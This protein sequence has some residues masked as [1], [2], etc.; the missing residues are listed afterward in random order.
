MKKLL[1]LLTFALFSTP[2]ITQLL[3]YTE[4]IEIQN[5]T[6]EQAIQKANRWAAAN[7]PDFRS[8]FQYKD[9]STLIYN[10]AVKSAIPLISGFYAGQ[11]H[12]YTYKAIIRVIGNTMK[13]ELKDFTKFLGPET[14]PT[15]D[16]QSA[17]KNIQSVKMGKRIR[18][19]LIKDVNDEYDN[20]D[21][22]AEFVFNGITNE[23][24]N[25]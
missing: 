22:N 11:Q 15:S 10:S 13:I 18:R 23:L 16:R 4:N 7:I 1:L 21:Q 6:S 5:I 14:L 12:Y 24:N 2:G 8:A 17:M 3:Y 9:E 19:N 25:N 20:L